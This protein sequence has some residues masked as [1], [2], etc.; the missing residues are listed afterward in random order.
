M[1]RTQELFLSTYRESFSK[2]L[3]ER[4]PVCWGLSCLRKLM[5]LFK[6]GTQ[7]NSPRNAEFLYSPDHL[8]YTF[9]RTLG[10]SVLAIT[11]H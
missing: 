7:E 2:H 6:E 1:V 9:S 10:K 5:S 8:N 4:I 3:R 11:C